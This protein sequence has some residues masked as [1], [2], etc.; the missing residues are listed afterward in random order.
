VRNVVMSIK[1]RCKN[2]PRKPRTVKSEDEKIY[3]EIAKE[4][5]SRKKETE[6]WAEYLN[7]RRFT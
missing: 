7:G 4:D 5:I 1:K 2:S 3:D 6:L